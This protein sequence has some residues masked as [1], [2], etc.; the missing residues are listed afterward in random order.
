M[1]LLIKQQKLLMGWELGGTSVLP[2]PPHKMVHHS[3]QQSSF[4][5]HLLPLHSAIS[6]LL[7]IYPI[8]V[9]RLLSTP[10]QS[11]LP[12][13]SQVTDLAVSLHSSKGLGYLC[14]GF[15]TS[16]GN[17]KSPLTKKSCGVVPFTHHSKSMC[18]SLPQL[19]S[20]R[21][22]QKPNNKFYLQK[23]AINHYLHTPWRKQ[24]LHFF[25]F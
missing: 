24:K 20:T 14:K 5:Q 17:C 21:E 25:R 22:C 6:S 9:N 18:R 4:S 23:N 7:F 15:S 19:A 11:H 8:F 13:Y 1:E 3:Q 12:N 2:P 10:E 16:F